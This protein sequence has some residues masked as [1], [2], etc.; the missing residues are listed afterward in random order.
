MVCDNVVEFIFLNKFS[1]QQ[2]FL[3]RRLP[4]GALFAANATQCFISSE[5]SAV[6]CLCNKIL[7]STW[8]RVSFF[9][10]AF[11]QQFHSG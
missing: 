10:T 9:L 5:F 4:T 6:F 3:G 1:F 11:S 2:R 7:H 8:V